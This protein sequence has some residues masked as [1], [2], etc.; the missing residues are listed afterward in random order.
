[1]RN[2]LQIRRHETH[3]LYFWGLIP[4]TIFVWSLWQDGNAFL[5]LID[6]SFLFTLVYI[7]INV[8]RHS[9]QVR[10]IRR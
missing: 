8:V 1:M 6:D 5:H 2:T 7:K 10:L 3:L 9:F 4:V